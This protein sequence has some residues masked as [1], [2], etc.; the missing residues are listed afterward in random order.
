MNDAQAHQ[1]RVNDPSDSEG[2]PVSTKFW[3]LDWNGDDIL[4]MDDLVMSLVHIA[5]IPN[6]E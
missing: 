2:P 6:R 5:Q 3:L 1:G 4:T